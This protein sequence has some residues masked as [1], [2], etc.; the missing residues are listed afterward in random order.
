M[1]NSIQLKAEKWV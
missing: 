1:R